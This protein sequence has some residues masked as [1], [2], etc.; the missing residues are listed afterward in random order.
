MFIYSADAGP[1][2]PTVIIHPT[3]PRVIS[4]LD[5]EL[6]TIG[7]PLAD[8]SYQMM[9]WSA[10]SLLLPASILLTHAAQSAHRNTRF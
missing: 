5:W 6:C 8:L 10:S 3:E 1:A 9:A 2:P 4:V 7:N